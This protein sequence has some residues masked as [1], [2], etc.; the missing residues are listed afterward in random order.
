MEYAKPHLSC[1]EQAEKLIRQGIIGDRTDMEQK[2]AGVSYYRLSAYWHPFRR[3][4]TDAE[5]KVRYYFT[6]T[7]FE[8]IWNHYLFDR[9]LRLLFMDAIERIEVALRSRLVDYYTRD[10]SP[11]DYANDPHAARRVAEL[12]RQAG[13]VDGVCDFKNCKYACV[14]HFYSKYGDCH[15]HLPFWIFAEVTEFGFMSTFYRQSPLN[16]RISIASEWGV[17]V[18]TLTSWLSCINALRNACAHHS[19]VW[20]NG[21]GLKPLLPK[22]HSW[23]HQLWFCQYSER[24]QLWEYVRNADARPSIDQTKT[25]ALL[26]ICRY[27]MRQIAPLSRWHERVEALFAEFEDSGINFRTMGLPLHW[28][29]HPL[30]RGRAVQVRVK[31]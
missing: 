30:W 18:A 5:G 6:N 1:A 28:Q 2:L 9:K 15:A 17:S 26:F 31:N 27:L 16:L 12:E 7:N 24:K 20:N 22:K 8:L 29:R 11:F 19:R 13:I 4:L 10:H 25:A 23:E 14:R 21:W 3:E